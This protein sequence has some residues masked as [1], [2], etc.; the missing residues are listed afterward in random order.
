MNKN[1]IVPFKGKA[2]ISMDE[3][4]TNENNATREDN[5]IDELKEHKLSNMPN[6]SV[7]LKSKC[8]KKRYS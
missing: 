6:R 1:K 4:A 7:S 5:S 2:N 3:E 8:I